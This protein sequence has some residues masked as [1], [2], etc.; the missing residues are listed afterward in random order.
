MMPFKIET[1]RETETYHQNCSGDR[2]RETHLKI[3]WIQTY[4]AFYHS[5]L[6]KRMI[7]NDF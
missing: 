3:Y 5:G 6:Q 4:V 7:R 2:T 1:H